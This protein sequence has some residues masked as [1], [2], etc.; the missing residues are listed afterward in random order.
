M[1]KTI[2]K[3]H[4]RIFVVL[5]SLLSLLVV[6]AIYFKVSPESSLD[7]G[8][9]ASSQKNMGELVFDSSKEKTPSKALVKVFKRKFG[10]QDKYVITVKPKKPIQQPDV[11]LYLN[12]VSLKNAKK[13]VEGLGQAV[14]LGELIDDREHKFLI[15]AKR[16]KKAQFLV[17]YSNPFAK[18]VEEIRFRLG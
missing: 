1:N 3:R 17:F 12:Q 16:L 15:D 10:G 8:S 2:R 11:L 13:P 18:V 9:G 5:S 7:S 14:L 6:L 4:F